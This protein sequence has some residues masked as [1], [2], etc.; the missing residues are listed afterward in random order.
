MGLRE[1]EMIVSVQFMQNISGPTFPASTG[2]AGSLS[3]KGSSDECRS[4]ARDVQEIA[5][6]FQ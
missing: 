1:S 5:G 3:Q 4:P 6:A 2:I